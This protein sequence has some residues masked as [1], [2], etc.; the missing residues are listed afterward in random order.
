MDSPNH[1]SPRRFLHTRV[2]DEVVLYGTSSILVA[3][4]RKAPD[5]AQSNGKADQGEDEVQLPRPRF[6]LHVA[7][8]RCTPRGSD[9]R[10]IAC[11]LVLQ[12]PCSCNYSWNIRLQGLHLFVHGTGHWGVQQTN[13][14]PRCHDLFRENNSVALQWISVTRYAC[15]YEFW[16]KTTPL[17]DLHLCGIPTN[18]D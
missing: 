9:S 5:V 11:L 3:E 8:H 16:I 13:N 12:L 18:C 15:E 4:I 10:W 7:A 2:C 14:S 6:S 1:D 17:V